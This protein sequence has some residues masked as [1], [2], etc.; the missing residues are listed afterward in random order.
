VDSAANGLEAAE[1]LDTGHF[2]AV[3]ADLRMPL[4]DGMDLL[5]MVKR[6]DSTIVF[7]IVTGFGTPEKAVEAMRLGS[8][9]FIAK[10]FA[11][12]VLVDA[13]R[14]ALQEE[15]EAP[16]PE[17]PRR[18]ETEVY[19]LPGQHTWVAPQADGTVLIGADREFFARAGEVVYCDLP[20]EGEVLE[21][22]RICASATSAGTHALARLECPISGT[23]IAANEAMGSRPWEVQDDPYGAAW[24]I[25]IA[26][27]HLEEDLRALTKDAHLAGSRN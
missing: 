11:P 27:S 8:A 2:D 18:A 1:K 5:H 13:L 9:D 6:K 15:T 24:L 10:P 23:V 14:R 25:R 20:L 19:R 26:P 21:K 7:V 17:T 22:G 12:S 3:V 4:L 16:A